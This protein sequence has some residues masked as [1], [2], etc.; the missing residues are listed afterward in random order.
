MKERQLAICDG[1]EL[2]LEKF[3]SYLLKKRPAGYEIL[4]FATVNQAVEASKEEGFEIFLVGENTYD[5]NVTNVN[6]AKIFIL[7]ENGLSGI[8]GYTFISKY[9]SMDS[10][11][12][13][14]LEEFA[15]DEGCGGTVRSSGIRARLTSFYSPDRHAGQNVAALCAAEL[16]A[17]MGQRVLYISMQP[18]SGFEELLA[19]KYEADLTDLLYFALRHPDK[20][21]YKLEAV[22][23][24]IG[25]VDYLPP[26]LDYADLLD[27]SE[28]EWQE[29]LE[30]L[31]S[32]GEYTDI[33]LDLTECCRG[34]YYMLDKSDKLYILND[35]QTERSRAALNQFKNLLLSKEYGRIIE[36]F[37]V[38]ELYENWNSCEVDLE[39]LPL[40]G[41][42]EYM[43]GIICCDEGK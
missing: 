7:K 31:L 28:K 17:D 2:Y 5:I 18:F 20:L 27:I 4:A 21:F 23:R 12:G 32:E 24:A 35:M 16:M 14:A 25:K 15:I 11:I 33:V 13:Q 36:K 41:L 9:Q 39:S 37:K 26:A 10:V 30:A 1:D 19:T 29:V 34:F 40:S 38:F 42:G 3:Q 6:A 43:K 22:K 8:K